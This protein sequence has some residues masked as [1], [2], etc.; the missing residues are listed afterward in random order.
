MCLPAEDPPAG[1][2]DL[3]EE[4]TLKFRLPATFLIAWVL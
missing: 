4:S 1:L 2:A 3:K